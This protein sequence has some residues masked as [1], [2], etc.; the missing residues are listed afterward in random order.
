V[1]RSGAQASGIELQVL[2]PAGAQP[3]VP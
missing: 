2:P 3:V 1:Y